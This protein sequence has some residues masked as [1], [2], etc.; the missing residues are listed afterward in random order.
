MR[1]LAMVLILLASLNACN[2]V[3]GIGEDVKSGGEAISDTAK[4]VKKKL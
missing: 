3:D 4:K 2:T 1:A